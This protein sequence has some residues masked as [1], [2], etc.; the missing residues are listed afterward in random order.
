[1]Q[2]ILPKRHPDVKIDGTFEAIEAEDHASSYPNLLPTLSL[3]SKEVKKEPKADKKGSKPKEPEDD[4][5]VKQRSQQGP[6][7]DPKKLSNMLGNQHT[8]LTKKS[9]GEEASL[10]SLEEPSLIEASWAGGFC[11][12]SRGREP[13]GGE[14]VP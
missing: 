10:A 11:Y 12:A 1:M 5:V 7:C 2:I 13:F 8:E 4:K 6:A 9:F 14:G 3:M